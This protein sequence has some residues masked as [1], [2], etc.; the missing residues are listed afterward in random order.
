MKTSVTYSE[1]K[2]VPITFEIT[3]E[4]EAELVA[5]WA[6]LNSSN[7]QLRDSVNYYYPKMQE[8]L[9]ENNACNSIYD[10]FDIVDDALI[11][12]DLKK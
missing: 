8:T 6:A 7:A 11:A 5:L 4:S 10:A 3:V 1:P 12:R 9:A 2:F